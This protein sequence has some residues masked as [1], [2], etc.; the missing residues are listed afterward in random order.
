VD[1]D[2]VAVAHSRLLLAGNPGT[3][4]IQADLREPAKILDDAQ[5]KLLLDFTQP[6]AV[7]VVAVLHFITD[8][9]QAARII[10][11]LRDALAPG[12]YLVICHACR[13]EQPKL[14]N[15]FETVYNSRVAAQ[16]VMRTRDEIA[17]LCDGFTLAEPGLVW[18]PEW[19]PDSPDDV[20]EDPARYWAL[21]GVGRYDGPPKA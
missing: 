3:T 14:A 11:T 16:L 15:S 13:D 12:S 19:R 9:G 17:R 10:A 2:D 21:V 18:I 7:F 8:N 5:T 1:N 20:P 6:V 4:V